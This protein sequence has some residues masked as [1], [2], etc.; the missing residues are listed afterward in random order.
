MS[1]HLAPVHDGDPIAEL[2]GLLHVVRRQDHRPGRILPHPA[3][4]LG[5]DVAG[6][7][8]VEGDGRL[9]QEN[10]AW[11]GHQTAHEAHLLT[12]TAGE[13]GD[14]AVGHL[15]EAQPLQEIVDAA[16]RRG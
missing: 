5:A 3:P 6:G 16:A 11:V 8:H 10:D 1:D 7:A 15:G 14:L 2:V 9:V 12:H 4:D 13:A